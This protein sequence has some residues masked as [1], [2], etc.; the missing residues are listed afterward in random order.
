[1]SFI[2][3]SPPRGAFGGIQAFKKSHY[4][5]VN[6]NSNMFWGWGG[7]DDALSWRVRKFGFK[8]TRPSADI[9]RYRMNLRHHYQSDFM[10]LDNMEL[11]KKQNSERLKNG[12]NSISSLKFTLKTRLERF[13]TFVSID[14]SKK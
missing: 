9:A 6:G 14:L 1:M 7:E 5:Q 8:L 12:L 10:N 11:L 13:C 2:F 4:I 3:R